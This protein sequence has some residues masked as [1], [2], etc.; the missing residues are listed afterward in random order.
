ML[1]NTIFYVIGNQ[2]QK[3]EVVYETDICILQLDSFMFIIF[4]I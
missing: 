1:A 2:K 3:Y 4:Y